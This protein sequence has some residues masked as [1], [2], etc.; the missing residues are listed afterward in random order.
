MLLFFDDLIEMRRRACAYVNRSLL[1]NYVVTNVKKSVITYKW[2]QINR[3]I[4]DLVSIN[5]FIVDGL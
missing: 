2:L 4:I 1:L 3:K 5:F